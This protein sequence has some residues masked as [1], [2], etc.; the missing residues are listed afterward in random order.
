MFT[1]GIYLPTAVVNEPN[2]VEAEIIVLVGRLKERAICVLFKGIVQNG[3]DKAPDCGGINLTF[4]TNDY[5]IRLYY[6]TKGSLVDFK[7]AG[8]QCRDG[9]CHE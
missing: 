8:P 3:V 5:V 4:N 9:Y 2:H 7:L 6:L 1:K